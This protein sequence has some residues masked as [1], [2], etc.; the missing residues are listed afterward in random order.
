MEKSMKARVYS[1]KEVV[2]M[3][4]F[5]A[6]IAISSWI[7]IPGTVPFTLQTLGVFLAVTVLGGRQGSLVVTAYVLLGALGVPVFSK[8]S[9]GFGALFGL[10]GGY[11]IGFIAAAL[12]MWLFEAMFGRKF[13]ILAFSAVL[14]MILC[15]VIGTAWF[16]YV[17]A[18]TKEPVGLQVI[19]GWCVYPFIIPDLLKIALALV[20]GNRIHKVY[21]N[22]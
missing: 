22:L 19:L 2:F 1:A 15:Y 10:T 12:V 21:K 3:G 11:I 4:I 17:F 18:K 5:V 8:F 7:S 20:I 16:M 9:G 13:F 6:L 14:G